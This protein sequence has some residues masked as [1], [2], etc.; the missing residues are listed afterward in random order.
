MR[1]SISLLGLSFF[2]T[3]PFLAITGCDPDDSGPDE[4]CDCI[5]DENDQNPPN[6]PSGPTCGEALCVTVEV[7]CDGYCESPLVVS[8]P[9]ALTCALTALRDRTPGIVR[10]STSQYSGQFQDHGYLLI[11]A[12]GTAVRRT[13]GPQD[14]SYM[15]GDAVLGDLPSVEHFDDCLA[16]SSDEERFDCLQGEL[17]SQIEVCDRG[18][19]RDEF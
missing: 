12:D 19:S 11:Q 8:N 2:A 7:A 9:E 16:S 14:L 10:W 4:G 3:L 17:R 15:A 13:F 1:T 6:A 5:V 18:W